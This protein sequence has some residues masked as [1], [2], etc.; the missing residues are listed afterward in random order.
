MDL[1]FY[2]DLNGAGNPYFRFIYNT[3]FERFKVKFPHINCIQEQPNYEVLGHCPSCPGG[4]SHFQII[5]PLNKKSILMSFWDRGMDLLNKDLGWGEYDIVQYIGGLGMNITS[6]E[7]K[8]QY[9][10]NHTR[11]QYPLGVPNSYEYVRDNYI[12]YN[13]EEKI[14]KAVFIGAV[15]GI[16][17]E[18]EKYLKD[19]P[20]IDW[21]DQNAGYSRESYYDKIKEYRLAISL[22]GHGELC[23]R[24]LEAMGLGIPPVRTL[25]HTQF[26]NPIIPDYHYIASGP[27]CDNACFTYHNIG[28]KELAEHY[29]NA[30]EN[31]I[32]NF[33]KLINISN[34]GREY[35]KMYVNPSYIVDL[36]FNLIKL[37]ELDI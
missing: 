27:A 33:D 4:Y 25:T 24:D 37:D 32:D 7:I 22:N 11:F 17:A 26:Y 10:I 23:L 31:N 21:Y 34:R 8:E 35:F 18:L 12:P 14:R 13:P 29:I 3:I 20:L 30:I 1:I 6:K 2:Y 28:V 16:R 5:N 19:H 15:Y 9:G 36:Y